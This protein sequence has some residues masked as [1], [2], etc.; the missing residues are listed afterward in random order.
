MPVRTTKR[1]SIST[2]DHVVCVSDVT[3]NGH[4]LVITSPS[5]SITLPAA[6]WEELVDVVKELMTSDEAS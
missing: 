3:F 2:L 4:D 1:F 5:G 6:Q